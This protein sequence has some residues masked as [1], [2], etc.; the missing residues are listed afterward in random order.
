MKS[1]VLKHKLWRAAVAAS[2][3]AVFIAATVIALTQALALPA[4]V[5]DATHG[6]TYYTASDTSVS[7]PLDEPITNENMAL[8]EKDENQYTLVQFIDLTADDED[9]LTLT[10]SFNRY[11][12]STFFVVVTDMDEADLQ[13]FSGTA[14]DEGDDFVI[15][16]DDDEN[17]LELRI[18]RVIYDPDPPEITMVTGNISDD[19]DWVENV[20]LTIDATDTLGEDVG[21]G[22]HATAYSFDDGETWVALNSQTFTSNGTV[23]IKV[24]DALEQESSATQVIITKIDNEPPT[25]TSVVVDPDDITTEAGEWSALATI[26]VMGAQ[27]AVSG[28]AAAA[29]SFDDGVSWQVSNIYQLDANGVY[30]IKVRDNAGNVLDCGEIDIVRFDTP[31]EIIIDEDTIWADW[32][33]TETTFEFAVDDV[34]SGYDMSSITGTIENGQV[35][36]TQ[37]TGEEHIYIATVT[38][39][40]GKVVDAPAELSMVDLMDSPG[41]ATSTKHIKIDREA[42]TI[43]IDESTIND[44]WSAYETSF[45]IEVTDGLGSDIASIQGSVASGQVDIQPKLGAPGV[46]TVTVTANDGGYT[47]T[48][49]TIEA[50]DA[51][52]N[53][54]QETSIKPIKADNKRIAISNVSVEK[55]TG[56]PDTA[57]VKNGDIIKVSFMLSDEGSGVDEGTVAVRLN[58]SESKAAVREGSVYSCVFAV[59]SD[60]TAAED[61]LLTLTSIVCDNNVGIRTELLN[62]PTG[63]R[64]YAPIAEGLSGLTFV[65][66]NQNPALAKTGDKVYLSFSTTHPVFVKD[67]YVSQTQKADIT[68]TKRND[69]SSAGKYDHEGYFTAVADY[70]YDQNNLIYALTLY[71]TAGNGEVQ[72]TQADTPGVTYFAPIVVSD[73]RI[74][75]DNA[76]DGALYA[77]NGDTLSVS[78]TTNHNVALSG[79]LVAGRAPSITK[80]DGAGVSKNWTLTYRLAGGELADLADIPFGFTCDD[81]AGNTSQQRTHQSPGVTN[82]IRYYAPITASTAIASNYKNSGYAKNGD[83]VAVTARTNHAASI[84]AATIMGRSA[85]GSGNNSTDLRMSYQ[86]PFGESSTSEGK[87]SFYYAV[88]D[89]AGNTL[90][91]NDASTSVIYDRTNPTVSITPNTISFSAQTITCTVIFEDEHLYASDISVLLNGEE[92]MTSRDRN[93]VSGTVFEKDVTLEFDGNYTISAT[94]YDRAG[95][96]SDPDASVSLTVDMISPQIRTLQLRL[97][98]PEVFMAGFVISEYFEFIDDNLKDVICTV[99]DSDGTHDWDI[100]EPLMK[101]G[102]N[103]INLIAV[104]M[105]DNSSTVVTYD[106]YIDGSAPEPVIADTLSGR[107]LFAGDNEQA[108]ISEMALEISLKALHFEGFDE[109]DRFTKLQLVDKDDK[110]VVDLLKVLSPNSD[111]G[112]IYELT[113]FGSY[114]LLVEAVDTVGNQTG[115]VAYS[116]QFADKSVFQKYYENTPL[117][118]GSLVVLVIG[119][120]AAIIVI[121]Q[122]RK[123]SPQAPGF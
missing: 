15:L 36:I 116:F 93:A 85:S 65:S 37:K 110:L 50:T 14:E 114:S 105:A 49:I 98:K 91:V 102:K 96:K 48:P 70:A 111:G 56:S 99:T 60:L 104:D 4:L 16:Q 75:S 109:P 81:A 46:Y 113:A 30:K 71:D 94:L 61:T 76:K 86:I 53:T 31:P 58:G 103:T 82:V 100:D 63:L 34:G 42:P 88:E 69:V 89:V 9:K 78:F 6:Y 115:L 22:L 3:A 40:D 11:E 7:I 101:D 38:A 43:S 13:E 62:Q 5:P 44:D 12:P 59:G 107:Q 108:F 39:D 106:L 51:V 26:T 117:F 10:G 74:V 95:N 119:A 64:Y 112:Y 41:S 90:T 47:N 120:A 122:R 21:V 18:I 80:T 72:K 32:A 29:Y 67:A 68:W 17:T 45:E 1:E 20:T 23:N 121:R 19:E 52:G 35:V 33:A 54:S 87:A 77:K 118:V 123:K 24:R 57:V 83:T 28:L 25:I 92:Q 27:D 8:F 66:G 55:I 97:D 73:V 2:I 84:T 79:V